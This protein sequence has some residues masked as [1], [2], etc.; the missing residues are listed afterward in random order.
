MDHYT[1][2]HDGGLYIVRG[3][4]PVSDSE[5][6][7]ASWSGSVETPIFD[8]HLASHLNAEMVVGSLESCNARRLQLGLATLS[9][10]EASAFT[11]PWKR[12]SLMQQ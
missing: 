10:S 2:T 3:N 11:G 5:C 6:L 4:I 12:Q 9:V 1:V 8:W 7:G